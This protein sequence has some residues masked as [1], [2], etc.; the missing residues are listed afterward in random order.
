MRGRIDP[1]FDPDPILVELVDS[2]TMVMLDFCLS[3]KE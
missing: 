2:L 1:V 3:G